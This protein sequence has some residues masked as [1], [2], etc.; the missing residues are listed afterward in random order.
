M[1]TF[2]LLKG[3][4]TRSVGRF[5][6]N[7]YWYLQILSYLWYQKKDTSGYDMPKFQTHWSQIHIF[8]SALS[9]PLNNIPISVWKRYTIFNLN[10][11]E[12][13]DLF[14]WTLGFD[15]Y[16]YCTKCLP[17]EVNKITLLSNNHRIHPWH[18]MKVKTYILGSP[19]WKIWLKG[20]IL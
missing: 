9:W 14:W 1:Y 15:I 2:P 12:Q 3:L 18:T 10:N 8:T 19:N 4:K 20:W 11:F 7:F 16:L 6:I 5:A 17:M 13:K